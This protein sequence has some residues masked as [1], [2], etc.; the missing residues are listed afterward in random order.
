MD[1][2]IE[3]AFAAALIAN[4]EALPL[5]LIVKLDNQGVILKEFIALHS[6]NK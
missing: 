1:M 6:L 3:Q 4:G 2:T 5:D